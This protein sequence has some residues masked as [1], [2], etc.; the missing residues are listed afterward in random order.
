MF[1]V[2]RESL[3]SQAKH[4]TRKGQNTMSAFMMPEKTTAIIATYL[5]QAANCVGHTGTIMGIKTIEPPKSLINA[6]KKAGCYDAEYDEYKAEKIYEVMHSYNVAALKARYGEAAEGYAP[7]DRPSGL[8]IQ[9]ETRREWL[10][11]LF[12]VARCYHYQCDEGKVRDT[13]FFKAFG[14]W[15]DEMAYQLAEMVVNEVRPRYSKAGEERNYKPWD[16]F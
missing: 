7:Y 13:E 11:N 14:E 12:T 5:A 10:S 6:L 8:S 15:I 9:E 1:I 4:K 2:A 3:P 16:Q